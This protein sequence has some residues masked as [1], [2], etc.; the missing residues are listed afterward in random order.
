MSKNLT[1][2]ELVLKHLNE[3][4]DKLDFEFYEQGIG[5]YDNYDGF[6][7]DGTEDHKNTE[8]LLHSLKI[9]RNLVEKAIVWKHF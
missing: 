1:P 9:A 6:D 8:S 5:F 3:V 4:I 7:G 2:N